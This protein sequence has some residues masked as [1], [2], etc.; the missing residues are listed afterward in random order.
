MQRILITR[1]IWSVYTNYT[2]FYDLKFVPS[3]LRGRCRGRSL[4]TQFIVLYNQYRFSF[5]YE[6]KSLWNAHKFDQYTIV[7]SKYY[8]LHLY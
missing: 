3:D 4:L 8:V 7:Y 1:R 6:C 5:H 2:T